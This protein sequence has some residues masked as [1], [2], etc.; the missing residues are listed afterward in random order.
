MAI[1]NMTIELTCGEFHPD[2]HLFAAGGKDGEIKLYSIT[3]ADNSAN[4]TTDGAVKD[5]SF[6]EN[7]T[8]L[9]SAS[10][11]STNVTI[12]DLRKMNVIKS[13]EIGSAVSSVAW[14][15]TGQFLAVAAA[16][17]VVVEQYAKSSKKWSEPLRKAVQATDVAWGAS[18]G[19][20]ALLSGEGG[21]VTLG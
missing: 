18:A 4:F 8:W 15:Y 21:L 17:C 12:W 11:N 5:L 14:D 13:L 2:G 19:S 16:G 9:A 6:S 10:A 3:T 1:T 20:L 7:G